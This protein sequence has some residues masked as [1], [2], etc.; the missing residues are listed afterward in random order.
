MKERSR[1]AILKKVQ[2]A[3]ILARFIEAATAEGGDE[4]PARFDA[5]FADLPLTPREGFIVKGERRWIFVLEH[6][7][8]LL[9]IPT[10]LRSQHTGA[11]DI[12]EAVHFR[13][14]TGMKLPH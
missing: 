2:G 14:H 10:V 6:R 12:E 9:H 4:L 3:Q 8:R 13:L 7:G 5:V 1:S 11:E